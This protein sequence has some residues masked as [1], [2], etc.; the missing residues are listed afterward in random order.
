MMAHKPLLIVAFILII[1]GFLLFS[2]NFDRLLVAGLGPIPYCD[3]PQDLANPV[4]VVDWISFSD[5]AGQFT[6]GYVGSCFKAS[7]QITCNNVKPAGSSI[8]GTSMGY[9]VCAQEQIPAPITQPTEPPRVTITQPPLLE[10]P[11]PVLITPIGTQSQQD[12]SGT[13]IL[14]LIII[15]V[16]L[17]VI[18]WRVR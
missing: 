5:N 7:G 6:D 12:T 14:I 17:G 13:L 11:T 3:P 10:E 9:S 8:S 4:G 18:W 15:V 1:L 2:G 16:A